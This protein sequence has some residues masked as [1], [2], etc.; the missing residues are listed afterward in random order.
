[1]HHLDVKSSFPNGELSEDVYV[2]QPEGFVLKGKEHLVY[3]LV[4]ALYGLK[5]APRAWYAKLKLFR[6]VGIHQVTL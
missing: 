2:S 1:M 6:E 3:K 5:Q 4:K